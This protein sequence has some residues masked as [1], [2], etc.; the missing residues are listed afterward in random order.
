MIKMLIYEVLTFL[1][2]INYVWSSYFDK[3]WMVNTKTLYYHKEEMYDSDYEAIMSLHHQVNDFRFTFW[4]GLDLPKSGNSLM[5]LD[6]IE[7][8]CVKNLLKKDGIQK[9]LFNNIW[10]IHSTNMESYVQEY[11]SKTKMQVGLN[12]NIFFV[13]S[14]LGIYNVTQVLGTGTFS[15]KYKQHGIL[16]NLKVPSIIQETKKRVD[17]E[18][19]TFIANYATNFPPYCFVDEDGS[20]SGILPDTLRTAAHYMNLTLMFQKPKEKNINRWHKK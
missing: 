5:V 8:D 16:E 6:D 7:P 3:F 13:T 14:Y 15:V 1:I 19:S 4:N 10:I 20:V 12:A 11:F 17:F 2:Q 18:G 9:S